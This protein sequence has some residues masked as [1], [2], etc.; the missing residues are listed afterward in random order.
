MPDLLE[1][2]LNVPL[3]LLVWPVLELPLVRLVLDP[4]PVDPVPVDP[5]PVLVPVDL[6][7][8][9]SSL[10]AVVSAF[11]KDVSAPVHAFSSG[12]DTVGVVAE[13]VDGVPDAVGVS[14]GVDDSLGVVLGVV[15]SLGVVLG[16]VVSLGVVLG[17]VDSLGVVE[18]L[19]VVD[20]LGVALGLCD[21]P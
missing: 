18:V 6:A 3:V 14:L 8:A 9:M 1:L 7:L 10:A 5:V 19:G 4:V 16:V 21:P 12:S 2:P 13:R 11:C 15:V 20:W 17:V